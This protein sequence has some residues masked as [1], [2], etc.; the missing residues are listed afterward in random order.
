MALGS[1]SNDM[2]V[3]N[4]LLGSQLSDNY[5]P[6][7]IA[8]MSAFNAQRQSFEASV[9]SKGQTVDSN[10]LVIKE[11]RLLNRKLSGQPNIGIEIE[12]V[13]DNVYNMIKT[14]DDP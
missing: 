13:Y 4:A 3:E 14:E 6:H 8:Q 7:S 10:N 2:L 12:K 1:M 9:K 5:N 11:L